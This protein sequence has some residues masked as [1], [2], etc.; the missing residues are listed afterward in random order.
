MRTTRIALV[1]LLA[2]A[3]L[4]GCARVHDVLGGGGQGGHGGKG[5]LLSCQ[6]SSCTVPVSVRQ[7]GVTL[8]EV[9]DLR[10]APDTVR[11]VWIIQGPGEFNLANGIDFRGNP[12][13]GNPLPGAKRWEVTFDNRAKR[14][15]HK[16]DVNIAGCP[17]YDPYIMN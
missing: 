12:R 11:V 13:V 17:T 16:Y 7:C 3:V 2:L 15:K 9:L 8:D 1:S 6:Q 10:S 14:T 5:R 4:A